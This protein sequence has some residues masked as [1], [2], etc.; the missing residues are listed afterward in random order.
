M[1]LNTLRLIQNGHHFVD[2]TFKYIFL[3]ENVR[4]FIE[5]SPN[6]VPKGLIN[7]ISALVQIMAWHWLG[8]KPLSAPM[9]VRLLM[10]ICVTLPQWVNDGN[11]RYTM[12]VIKGYWTCDSLLEI[13]DI[14]V[15]KCGKIIFKK[16]NMFPVTWV[17]V[18]TPLQVVMLMLKHQWAI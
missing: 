17:N 15:L 4:I 18:R 8:N 2:Y 7:N 9:M 12:S 13:T 10:H 5:I 14:L 1:P 6:F 16:S 3:N 11:C